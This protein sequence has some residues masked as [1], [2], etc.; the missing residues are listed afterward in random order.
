M[1]MLREKMTE[2]ESDAGGGTS[3]GNSK[4]RREQSRQQ[5]EETSTRRAELLGYEKTA[6]ML[7]TQL[8][9]PA[10]RSDDTTRAAIFA[11][12]SAVFQSVAQENVYEESDED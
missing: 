1:S 8:T 2:L 12:L 3:G 11:T 4:Q 9:A 6:T 5:R 7:W 10:R